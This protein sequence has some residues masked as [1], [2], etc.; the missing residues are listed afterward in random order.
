MT[1]ILPV[2]L[3]LY[4]SQNKKHPLDA[5]F[6]ESKGWFKFS[7]TWLITNQ[8][9]YSKRVLR[10]S[11]SGMQMDFSSPDFTKLVGGFNPVEKYQS[12]WESSP[13]R[14]ENKTY[15]KPPPRVVRWQDVIHHLGCSPQGCWLSRTPGPVS[16]WLTTTSRVASLPNS[17]N[18]L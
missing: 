17:P 3:D 1:F 13:S 18:G 12:K 14:G 15:L 9:W 4:C 5:N 10:C 6:Y 7:I 8:G 2:Y 11:Q 16:K